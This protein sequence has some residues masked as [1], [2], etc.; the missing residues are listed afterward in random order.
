MMKHSTTTGVGLDPGD[1][2]SKSESEPLEPGLL[3]GAGAAFE[4]RA[5][6]PTPALIPV[7]SNPY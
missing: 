1:Q 3:G 2:N 7:K 5:L 4:G 6:A